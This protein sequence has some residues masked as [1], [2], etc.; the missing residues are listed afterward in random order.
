MIIE[1]KIKGKARP[2]FSNGNTYTSTDTINYEQL[3]K[4]EY[5]MQHKEYYDH[6]IPLIVE[7][8]AYFQYP[9]AAT[10]SI[11]T[12]EK[13][14]IKHPV[15]TKKPDG[16]NIAKIICDSLNGVAYYDDSQI[17]EMVVKKRWSEKEHVEVNIRTYI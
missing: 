7:I 15:P 5:K 13:W 3:V 14:H 11:K 12:L 10:K 17:A 6:D 1:G 4:W 8:T 16:D 9:K 2:R